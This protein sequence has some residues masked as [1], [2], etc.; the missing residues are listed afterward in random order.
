MT[1]TLAR[2]LPA[3]KTNNEV[4]MQKQGNRTAVHTSQLWEFAANT[5]GESILE[6]E[7][8]VK[9]H[10]LAGGEASN[11]V[12]SHRLLH[13]RADHRFLLHYLLP[14]VKEYDRERCTATNNV[15]MKQ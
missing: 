1:K 10:L 15:F 11:T 9:A 4:T 5:V 14:H 3:R 8:M 7:L 12:G 13:G 2:Q 6:P